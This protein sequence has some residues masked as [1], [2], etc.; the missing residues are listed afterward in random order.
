MTLVN[1]FLG[2]CIIFGVL[3]VFFSVRIFLELKSRGIKTNFLLLRLF[4][5]QYA[6]QYKK[7][8]SQETG[9]P[10]PLFYYWVSS[11]NG[12]LVC[13]IASWVSLKL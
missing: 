4:I 1:I 5:L 11:I 10:S 3:H 12:A 13:L 7:I 6:S 9:K 2:L 8:T